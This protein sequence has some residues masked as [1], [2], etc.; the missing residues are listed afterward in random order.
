MKRSLARIELALGAVLV[1]LGMLLQANAELCVFNAGACGMVEPILA[2]YALLPGSGLIIAGLGA[3][4][5]V[6]MAVVVHLPLLVSML[7]LISLARG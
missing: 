5:G 1:A 7:Y 4:R 2:L 3:V 6:K